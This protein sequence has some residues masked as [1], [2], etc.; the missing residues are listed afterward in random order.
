MA[1]L[2]FKVTRKPAVLVAPSRPNPEEFLYLSNIDDQAT[3]RF[4][5]PVVQLYRFDP[6]KN[7]EDPARVI[8]EGLA[9]VLVIYYPFAGRVREAPGGKLVLESTGE[10]VLFVEA[11]ADV[12]LEELGDLLP[13]FPC[14]QDLIYDVPD[15]LTITNL[16]LLLI[17]VTRLK[18]GGFIFAVTFNHT[19]TDGL[20][21]V[22][23]M[24]ALAEMVKGATRPSVLPVWKRENL[25]PQANPVVKFPHYEYDQIEDRDGKMVAPNE[26]IHNS[27]FFGHKAF[28]LH[29]EQEVRF[30]FPVNIRT[31]LHP[32]LPGGFYGN[33]ISLACARTTAEELTNKP[34]SFA[35]KLINK[36]R[37]AVNDEYIRSAIDLMELKGRPHCTVV[38]SFFVSDVTKIDFRNVDFGWGRAAYGGPAGG[39]V[40]AVSGLGNPLISHRNKSGV[41]GIV[42]PLCLPSATMRRFEAEIS[43][44]IENTPP[45][46]RSYI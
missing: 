36:S 16:P 35:V 29:A 32:P 26:L 27:F 42:V 41:E 44:A 7:G 6:S 19:I 40:G 17:Q 8:R 38:G 9:N 37:T 22:Q 15:T 5:I 46:A 24:N 3:L 20:G 30:I 2:H 13:S 10:G 4:H 33:A 34:L 28:Q 12:A 31:K 23:F 43:H 11:D 18:C 1:S 39:G 25:R 45:F 14:W 21:L